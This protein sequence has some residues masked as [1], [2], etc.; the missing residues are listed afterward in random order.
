MADIVLDTNI[1]ADLLAQYYK[2]NAQ[3]GSYF[4]DE[5][6]L[7]KDLVRALNRILR[8]HL[9]THFENDDD[10]F[11]GLVV[12][13]SL[14]FVEIARQFD[15]V[16]NGRFTIEQFAAF[17]DQ[18]PEWFLISPVDSALFPHLCD[19]PREIVL[20][21]GNIKPVEWADAIHI[22]TAISRGETCLLAVTDST[23]KK[24]D[25]IRDR[26]I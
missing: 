7:N 3:K 12:A 4:E 21:D 8:W 24:V 5:G 17:I 20:P 11:P 13:S 9:Q 18:P 26:V 6:R 16:A 19:L 10:S 15:E 14:A 2:D 1:L 25:P 23:I 22:A